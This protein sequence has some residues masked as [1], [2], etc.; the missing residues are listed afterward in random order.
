MKQ[1]RI[2]ILKTETSS[3]ASTQCRGI[4]HIYIHIY[5]YILTKSDSTDIYLNAGIR[6]T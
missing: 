5:I 3:E 4:L 2:L 1:I 6:I